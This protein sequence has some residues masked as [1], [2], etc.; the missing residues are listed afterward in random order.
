MTV[1][2]RKL[3]ESNTTFSSHRYLDHYKL[4]LVSDSNNNKPEH[5]TFDKVILQTINIILNTTIVYGVPLTRWL[6]SLVVTIKKI[7]VVPRINEQR[8]INIYEADYNLLLKFIWTN[9]ATKYTAMNKTIGKNPPPNSTFG[10]I[11]QRRL[12]T[13]SLAQKNARSF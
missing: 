4:F 1:G 6:T 10:H 7:P 11:R 2:F 12:Y 13:P 9:K 3:N 8:I 5:A